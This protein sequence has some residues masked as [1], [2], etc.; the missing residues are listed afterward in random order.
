MAK[1]TDA[2]RD[3]VLAARA[4]FGEELENLEASA[5]AAFD[6][7]AKIRRS[8]AK[9]AAIVGGAGFLVAGGPTRL[10]RGVQRVVRGPSA[11]MPRSMLPKEIDKTLRKLGGDGDKVRGALERDFASY[12]KQARKDRSGLRTLLLGAARPFVLTGGKMASSW[13]FRTDEQG[14]QARLAQVRAR[15]ERQRAGSDNDAARSGPAAPTSPR[16]PT[17]RLGGTTPSGQSE[18]GTSDP[19]TKSAIPGS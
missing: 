10:W 5:R 4:T 9:A 2:A 8:P 12:A 19:G 16:S 1:E 11:A 3:R 7:P 15:A 13:L 17:S 6:V 14:F 18:R